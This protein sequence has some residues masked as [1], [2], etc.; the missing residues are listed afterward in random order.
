VHPVPPGGLAVL[1]LDSGRRALP[2]CPG[3]LAGRAGPLA[4][5]GAARQVVTEQLSRWWYL[6]LAA[7]FPE[8]EIYSGGWKAE[9]EL[10]LIEL[11]QRVMDHEAGWLFTWV[12]SNERDRVW[13]AVSAMFGMVLERIRRDRPEGERVI[14]ALA[15]QDQDAVSRDEIPA[16]WYPD[17]QAWDGGARGEE[18]AGPD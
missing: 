3:W 16:G 15:G 18:K 4:V 8:L 5:R 10:G 13:A 9:Q 11:G 14:R 2:G 7:D 17:V 1:G 6:D 12:Y